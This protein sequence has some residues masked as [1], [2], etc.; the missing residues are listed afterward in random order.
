MYMIPAGRRFLLTVLGCSGID[1]SADNGWVRLESL[2][3]IRAERF[4]GRGAKVAVRQVGFG[5]CLGNGV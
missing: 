2:P 3:V 1:L 5:R 4:W